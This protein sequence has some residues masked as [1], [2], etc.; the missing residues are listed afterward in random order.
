MRLQKTIFYVNLLFSYLFEYSNKINFI[1][2][3]KS[4]KKVS[5]LSSL[6]KLKIFFYSPLNA[7][8]K[9]S[10]GTQIVI[11]DMLFELQKKIKSSAIPW[12]IAFSN[13]PPKDKVD[14]L[15]CFKCFAPENLIGNPKII[16]SICDE[17]ENFWLSL[18]KFHAVVVSSSLTFFNL[19]RKKNKNTFYISEAESEEYVDFGLK[20]LKKLPSTKLYNLFW[21]GGQNSLSGLFPLKPFLIELAKKYPLNL[22]IVSG[23][24]PKCQYNWGSITIIHYP[25]SKQNMKTCAR[26]CALGIIPSRGTIRTSFL[27]P[28]SRVRALYALGVPTIGDSRVPDVV[29]FASH[30]GGPLSRT[31]KEFIKKIE[32]LFNNPKML[33]KISLKGHETVSKKYHNKLSANQWI[34]FFLE[35]EKIIK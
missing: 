27:K 33:N 18:G 4:I 21:H 26:K 3:S 8:G 22:Y 25:W 15:V 19:I 12:K 32:M 9:N 7:R 23:F 14:Y 11:I 17:G 2:P 1:E 24:K 16:L 29:E 13:D 31:P 20:N 6:N 10:A 5:N 35:Q 30:F 34:N 28:S